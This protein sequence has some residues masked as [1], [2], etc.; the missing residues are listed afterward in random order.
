MCRHDA[1]TSE[2]AHTAHADSDQPQ[3]NPH[4]TSI[5]TLTIVHHAQADMVEQ[6]DNPKVCA[7]ASPS[8]SHTGQADKRPAASKSSKQPPPP[9]CHIHGCRA[10]QKFDAKGYTGY[11]S[12]SHAR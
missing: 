8:E 5:Q 2:E 11:C 7:D 4:L 1:P 3:S 6:A 12:D 9:T 10:S